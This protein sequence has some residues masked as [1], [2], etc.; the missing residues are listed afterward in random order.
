MTPEIVTSI[1]QVLKG[2]WQAQRLWHE[3][4]GVAR[5]KY[6]SKTIVD[7]IQATNEIEAVKSTRREIAQV[8]DTADTKSRGRF[9]EAVRRYQKLGRG[10]AAAPVSLADLRQ[11]YE[12]VAADEIGEDD[13]PDG[14]L[15]RAKQV[16]I[17]SGMKVI[18]TGAP[19]EARIVQGLNIMLE[20]SADPHIP[21][22]VRAL[23][24]HFI[25]EYIHPFYD[26]NGRTGRYLLSVALAESLP[27]LIL[28]RV[29]VVLAQRK[30]HY[31]RTFR[32][33]EHPLN[34]GDVTTFIGELL[35][36]L[37][38]GGRD[39]IKELE[40]YLRLLNVARNSIAHLGIED[41]NVKTVLLVL[42]QAELFRDV[43][44]IGIQELIGAVNKSRPTIRKCTEELR[45]KGLVTEVTK[46]PLRFRLSAAGREA[47]GL[48]PLA[49]SA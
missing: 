11:A 19:T 9:A 49:T 15:F 1:E 8:L 7:E 26:G 29:S 39:V 10:D 41:V 40:E 23:A 27:Q 47:V 28:P 20:Q 3:L 33:V 18:H 48:G 21:A 34:C 45:E 44:A 12:D 13:R 46:K 17:T 37:E 2:A 43:E 22:L 35:N 30:D 36:I 38:R 4:P 25:F 6:A 32:N 24:G 42:A 14:E 16:Y 5:W 31:Y